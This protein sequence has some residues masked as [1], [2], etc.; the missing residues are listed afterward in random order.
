M[1]RFLIPLFCCLTFQGFTQYHD[2]TRLNEIRVLASHNS[3][4]KKPNPKVL[5]FLSRF[6]KQLGASNDPIQL[7]YGHL[8]LSE[9]FDKYGIRGIE[10]DINYDP[11]GGLYS[12]RKLNMF[13]FGIRQRVKDKRMTEPGFKVLHIADV[14]YETNYLTFKDVLTEVK[15]WSENHPNHTPLFINIEAKGSNPGD[16]SKFLRKMGFKKAIPFDSIAYQILD[17][18]IFSV[19]SKDN[20]FFPKELKGIY[21]SIQN[22]IRTE[23][24]PL[25]TECLGKIIFI[26]EGNNEH[27]YRLKPYEHPMFVYGNMDD[28]HTAFLLRND[29]IGKETQ[30]VELS[31]F[32]IVRTRSDAGTIE[33]RNN[34]YTRFN[35]AWKSNAQIISTDYYMSDLRFSNYQIKF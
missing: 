6:K 28:T 29:P 23:G 9:Q 5:K 31:K 4:K 25:L 14:D 12:K 27:I 3:Y 30:I 8:P 21:S 11:N 34:D 20:I 16:E 17:Q 35:A 18:E 24:W 19:L 15:N 32:F 13:L 2:S 10:I 22:R 1:F 33:A 7:D 26:L